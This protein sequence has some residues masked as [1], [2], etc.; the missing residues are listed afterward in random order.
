MSS[1]NRGYA[2]H[3]FDYYV[4]PKWIVRDF[5]EK[6]EEKEGMKNPED[7]FWLDVGCGGDEINDASYMSVIKEKYNPTKLVGL[8]IRRDSHA[9]ITMDF[10]TEYTPGG[11]H[12]DI[13]IANPP[14]S[15]A[16]EFIEKALSIVTHGGYVIMLQRLNFFGSKARREFFDN[17]MPHSLYVS[18]KRPNF[19]PDNMQRERKQNGL[20][21]LGG[22]SNEYGHFVWRKG[23]GWDYTKTYVV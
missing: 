5:L 4:T 14:F 18:S 23:F 9:S 13:I 11:L 7:A 15:K 8:D 2:R 19:I 10:L 6:F 22:D 21:R 16:V 1:T 20:K 12:P 3:E 17:N